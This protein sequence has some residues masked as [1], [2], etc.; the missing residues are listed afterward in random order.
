MLKYFPDDIIKEIQSKC[1][2][3]KQSMYTSLQYC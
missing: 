2:P 3:N 1:P